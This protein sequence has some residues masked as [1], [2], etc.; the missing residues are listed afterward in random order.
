[1]TYDEYVVSRISVP[2]SEAEPFCPFGVAYCDK[3]YSTKCRGCEV[4]LSDYKREFGEQDAPNPEQ[5]KPRAAK[6]TSEDLRRLQQLPL[7]Q[8]I[9]ITMSRIMEFHNRFPGKIYCSFSGGKDSTVLLHIIRRLYSDV[10]AVFVDT[11]LEYPEVRQFAKSVENVIILRPKMSFRQVIKQYGYPL[12]SKEVSLQIDVARRN[13]EGRTALKFEP[14]NEH[15]EKY[16]GFSI[17]RWKPVK[18]SSIPISAKCCTIMKK[19]PAKCFEKET[20]MHPITGMMAAESINRETQWREHGCNIYDGKRPLSNPMSFWTEQD[21]L[22]YILRYNLEYAS[23]YGE[24][25]RGED[26]LLHTTGCARTGCVYCLFGAHLEK[27]PSRLQK[28]RDSHP[29]LYNYCMRPWEEGGLGMRGVIDR[30]NEL[31]PKLAHIYY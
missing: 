24:I 27:Q 10:P 20:G 9:Q 30:F 14:G 1:M 18:D 7:Q 3:A 4:S 5:T 21:V 12:I 16:K 29:K 31:S 15:D 22:E 11:G 28:L 25:V 8:K 17:V 2:T 19:N 26:G 23:V 6:Y 13:P